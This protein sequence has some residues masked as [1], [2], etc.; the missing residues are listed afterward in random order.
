MRA[1]WQRVSPLP[2]CSSFED[3]RRRED[4]LHLIENLRQLARATII[5]SSECEP[6]GI[7]AEALVARR[8]VRRRSSVECDSHLRA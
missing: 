6:C 4:H 2:R 5:G 3:I 8:P 1:S 7:P